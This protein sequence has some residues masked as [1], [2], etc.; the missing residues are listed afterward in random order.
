LYIA[1]VSSVY[2][3]VENLDISGK[4]AQAGLSIGAGQAGAN[5]GI[6][7]QNCYV[8]DVRT[9]D[10]QFVYSTGGIQFNA[11]G[12]KPTWFDGAVIRNNTV[13]N[14]SR[15]GIYMTGAWGDRPGAAWGASGDLYKN[16]N[17]GWWPNDNC[18]IVGNTLT[19]VHGDGILVISAKDTHIEKNYLNDN[20]VIGEDKTKQ[21]YCQ[22]NGFSQACATVWVCNTNGSVMQNNEV[23]YT[24]LDAGWVDGEAFDIDGAN[25]E[26]Y[27]QYNYTHDNQGGSVLLCDFASSYSFTTDTFH[28]I[29]FNLS[30]DDGWAGGHGSIVAA[31]TRSKVDIYNNTFIQRTST[32]PL[33]NI[34][35][36]CH[37]YTFRNN[38]FYGEGAGTIGGAGKLVNFVMDNNVYAGGAV[39]PAKSGLTVKNVVNQNPK[40]KNAEFT[41]AKNAKPNMKG[42]IDAF[43]PTVK[44]NGATSIKDNGGKDI[45]GTKITDTNFYGCIKY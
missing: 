39:T 22:T 1:S 34:F 17:D 24:H 4:D 13:E 27:V 41:H 15:V 31:W 3:T 2:V 45:N 8:H 38:I 19:R 10:T 29:R 5:K 30:I 7:V 18:S 37:N 11:T 23:G 25:R 33:A 20:F 40:F 44:I 43:T 35:D 14:V 32:W 12:T 21:A 28:I 6:I 16:D 42:A 26:A 36:E 9:D